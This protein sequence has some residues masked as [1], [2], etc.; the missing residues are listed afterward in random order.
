MNEGERIVATPGTMGG[1]PR[2]RGTR[3]TVEFLL[4]LMSA[5]WSTPQILESY[6]HLTEA[7]IRAALAFAREYLRGEEIIAVEPAET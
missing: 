1:R 7:D 5:G 6:P 2:I 4:G 3:I